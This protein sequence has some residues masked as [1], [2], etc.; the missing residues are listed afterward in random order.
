RDFAGDV[1]LQGVVATGRKRGIDQIDSVL[2]VENPEFNAGRIDESIDPGKLDAIDAFFHG[3]QAELADHGDVFG[4]VD[5]KLRAVA[6]W[7]RDEIDGS[8]ERGK[9]SQ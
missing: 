9:E 4:V 3:Q 8:L 5:R 2:L 6:S 1:P 7:Q